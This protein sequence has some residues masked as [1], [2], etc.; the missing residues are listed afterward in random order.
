MQDEEVVDYNP[1]TELFHM[2][3]RI[4]W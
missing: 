2:E 3:E 4:L 1:Q